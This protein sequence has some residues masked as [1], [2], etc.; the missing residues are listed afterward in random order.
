MAEETLDQIL[1]AGRMVAEA[2]AKMKGKG[3][4]ET[5][6]AD[7]GTHWE[8]RANWVPLYIYICTLCMETRMD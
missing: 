6:E 3:K 2:V 5:A 8:F 7:D 1:Q 4:G